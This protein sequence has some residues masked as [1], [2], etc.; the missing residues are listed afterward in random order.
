MG[1]S[2]L[3]RIVCADGLDVYVRI[4]LAFMM[5]LR[6]ALGGNALRR[7]IRWT[8]ILLVG[9]MW[10]ELRSL[11]L[12]KVCKSADPLVLP[13]FIILTWLLLVSFRVM[14][15]S[16]A[17]AFP[18]TARPLAMMRVGIAFSSGLSGLCLAGEYSE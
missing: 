13:C 7:A 10:L 15:R 6:I 4:G 8:D 12:V 16:I 2:N 14:D 9:A 5:I 18:A 17:A 11:R 1:L 3:L